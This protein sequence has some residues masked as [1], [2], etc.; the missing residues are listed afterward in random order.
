MTGPDWW[1]GNS[2]VPKSESM[3]GRMVALGLVGSGVYKQGLE[4]E[5]EKESL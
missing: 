5:G 1:L 3:V 4:G 2:D